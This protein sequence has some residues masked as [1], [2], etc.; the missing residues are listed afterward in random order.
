MHDI[1]SE[2]SEHPGTGLR[3]SESFHSTSTTSVS[4]RRPKWADLNDDAD[5]SDDLLWTGSCSSLA[6]VSL[7]SLPVKCRAEVSDEFLE[8][9]SYTSHDAGSEPSGTEAITRDSSSARSFASLRRQRMFPPPRKQHEKSDG[10]DISGSALRKLGEALSKSTLTPAEDEAYWNSVASSTACSSSSERPSGSGARRSPRWSVGAEAHADGACHPCIFFPKAEGCENGSACQFC[11]LDHEPSARHRRQHRGQGRERKRNQEKRKPKQS[12]K[13]D[14]ASSGKA[15]SS[16]AAS[17]DQ[18]IM[19][20]FVG[21]SALV[22]AGLLQG[23]VLRPPTPRTKVPAENGRTCDQGDAESSTSRSAVSTQASVFKPFLAPFWPLSFSS[24]IEG[25][26]ETPEGSAS[27]IC[28]P[29]RW[30]CSS[31]GAEL[32][33]SA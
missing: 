23:R 25:E 12:S 1:A 13:D 20:P 21:P 7:T 31:S 10:E 24:I 22:P 8:A 30:P 18:E 3:T 2:S 4:G 6:P 14:S 26:S 32:G 15:G 28:T 5:S 29:E 9:Q 16:H 27:R 11:H 19:R 17:V 33:H